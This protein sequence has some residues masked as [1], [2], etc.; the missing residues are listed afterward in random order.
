MNGLYDMGDT[1]KGND[2]GHNGQKSTL[3]AVS[4]SVIDLSQHRRGKPGAAWKKNKGVYHGYSVEAEEK[5]LWEEEHAAA[6][7]SGNHTDSVHYSVLLCPD[8][9]DSDRV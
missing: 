5:V 9:R 6:I 4:A 7:S 3:Y 1:E 8:V 2:F